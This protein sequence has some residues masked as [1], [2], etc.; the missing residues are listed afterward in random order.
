MRPLPSSSVF[1]ECPY[2]LTPHGK[3]GF[4]KVRK[5]QGDDG[6]F[7][8]VQGNE[9]NIEKGDGGKG[10]RGGE[11]NRTSARVLACLVPVRSTFRHGCKPRCHRTSAHRHHKHIRA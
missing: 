6:H 2:L 7:I 8:K 10:R 5:E 3:E 11:R 1:S 4:Q 9:R